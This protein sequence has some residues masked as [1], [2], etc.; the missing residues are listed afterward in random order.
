M[1]IRFVSSLTA[2][3]EVRLA[4]GLLKA[5]TYLLDQWPITYTLRIDAGDATVLRYSHTPADP[6]G[7]PHAQ[8]VAN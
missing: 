3:D 5:F 1:E 6:A 4:E 8:P 2:E 7:T